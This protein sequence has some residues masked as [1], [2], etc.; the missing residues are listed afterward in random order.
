MKKLICA[1]TVLTVS[2]AQGAT[3]HVD[4]ANCPTL[5]APLARSPFKTIECISAT[6]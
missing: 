6:L 1:V 3:I 2:T 5:R 4:A